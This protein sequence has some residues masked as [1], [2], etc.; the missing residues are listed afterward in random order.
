MVLVTEFMFPDNKP[1]DIIDKTIITCKLN[2]FILMPLGNLSKRNIIQMP[3][4]KIESIGL[5]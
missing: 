1:F 4:K 3:I 2:I 5:M